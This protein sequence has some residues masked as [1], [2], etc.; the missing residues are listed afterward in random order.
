MEDLCQRSTRKRKYPDETNPL[1][2]QDFMKLL[3]LSAI[4]IFWCLL[5]V[6]GAFLLYDFL[7][8]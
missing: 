2:P 3:K 1:K 4:L 6:G 5:I 7:K 8:K